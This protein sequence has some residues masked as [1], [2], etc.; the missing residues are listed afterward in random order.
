MSCLKFWE[1]KKYMHI[2]LGCKR[3]HKPGRIFS[4]FSWS[5]VDPEFNLHTS[6]EISSMALL[7]PNWL[8]NVQN[9]GKSFCLIFDALIVSYFLLLSLQS[10][11]PSHLI[12]EIATCHVCRL[13][14]LK[15]RV[16]KNCMF[17]KSRE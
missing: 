4:G 14:R 15:T 2:V 5:Y 12:S 9:A 6:I 16:I 11:G 1:L 7:T 13:K 8:L 3:I 10:I 17:L